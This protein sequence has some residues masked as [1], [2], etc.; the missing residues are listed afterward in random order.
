MSKFS[1]L[2]KAI[3]VS[4]MIGSILANYDP[5]KASDRKKPIQVLKA[6]IKKMMFKRSRSNKKEF[7]DA[8][9]ISDVIW[10]KA[11]EHF[12]KQ[13]VTIEAVAITIRLY[14]LY[15][16]Q[17][18]RFTNI[19]ERQIEAF[20]RG[21]DSHHYEDSSYIVADYLIEKLAPFTGA[22]RENSQ[23]LQNKLAVIKQNR[24]LEGKQ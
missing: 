16:P 11:I 17:L 23:E 14:D 19:N 9:T 10:R 5:K 21:M 4:S 24:I 7:I 8:V 3:A 15:E 22:K 6:R 20:A 2:Q 13:N 12:E 1:E 18:S